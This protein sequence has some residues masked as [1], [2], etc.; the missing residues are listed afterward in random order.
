VQRQLP[1]NMVATVG[2]TRRL[3]KGNFGSRNLAVPTDT[4]IPLTV[5]EVNS[6]QT[7]TVYNQSPALRG[8]Q[9]ILYSNAPELDSVYNGADFSVDKRMSNRWMMTGGVSLGKTIG[10]VGP[11][12]LNNPNSQQFSRGLTG[13]DTPFSLRMSG[14]YDLPYSVSASATFQH[15]VGYPETTQVSVGNN[16]VALTQGT[17]T[18]TVAPVGTTRLPDL[19]QLDASFRRAFRFGRKVYQARLDAYNLLN[20]ATTIARNTVLGPTYD[21]VTNLQRGRLVKLG[22]TVDF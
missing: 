15:Q 16:T 3:K 19:N 6:G 4:Y 20:N 14:V 1:G 21:F 5:T 10:Y 13:M 8:Q 11:T 17:T 2:Y 9:N 22:M 18:L 7:V 12:D